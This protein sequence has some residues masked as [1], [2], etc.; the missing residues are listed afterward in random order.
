MSI[1]S[2]KVNRLYII[3]ALLFIAYLL[4]LFFYQ[5]NPGFQEWTLGMSQSLADQWSLLVNLL[6]VLVLAMGIRSAIR[7][8]TKHGN[9]FLAI[10]I[11]YA[12][13]TWI[14]SHQTLETYYWLLLILFLMYLVEGAILYGHYRVCLHGCP[15]TYD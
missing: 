13:V 2:K 7:H 9:V 8:K 11:I 15:I 14:F 12:A 4:V 3:Q 1:T 6:A 5:Q 10:S